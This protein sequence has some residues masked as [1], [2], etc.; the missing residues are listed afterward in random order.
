MVVDVR[1]QRCSAGLRCGAVDVDLLLDLLRRSPTGAGAQTQPHLP[2]LSMAGFAGGRSPD[3]RMGLLQ[4][5][6]LDS[7]PRHL[8]VL[9][10]EGVLVVGPTTHNVLNSLPPHLAGLGPIDPE[11]L[12]FGSG[13]RSAR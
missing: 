13:G 12:E 9:A 6:G 5:R 8:P 1:S 11:A 4:R 7:A 2:H 10:V 3:R